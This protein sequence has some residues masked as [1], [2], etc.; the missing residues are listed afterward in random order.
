MLVGA[1]GTIRGLLIRSTVEPAFSGPREFV[2]AWVDTEV[3]RRHP[4]VTFSTALVT[5]AD[6]LGLGVP[7]RYGRTAHI[8]VTAVYL[9][10][11]ER[12]ILGFSF[13]SRSYL[14]KCI[15]KSAVPHRVGGVSGH[16]Q[17]RLAPGTEGHLNSGRGSTMIDEAYKLPESALF[18][19]IP[20]LRNL[21][22]FPLSLT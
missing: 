12:L 13:D 18:G 21:R 6:R 10:R 7:D 20:A 11:R 17:Q 15:S 22:C 19:M 16:V 8:A 9:L 2:Q 1:D 14:L 5:L 3:C 4:V